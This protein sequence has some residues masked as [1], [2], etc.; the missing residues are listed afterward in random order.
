M[1]NGGSLF[2]VGCSPVALACSVN[3]M[4]VFALLRFG[5]VATPSWNGVDVSPLNS[6]GVEQSKVPPVLARVAVPLSRSIGVTPSPA[7]ALTETYCTS[8]PTVG[9]YAVFVMVSPTFAWFG[10]YSHTSLQPLL[11]TLDVRPPDGVRSDCISVKSLPPPWK[12]FRCF[13]GTFH[14]PVAAA[15]GVVTLNDTLTCELGGRFRF[16]S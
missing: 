9:V 16:R 6:H 13:A 11:P 2:G 5:N 15:H 4:P 12:S 3:S 14:V 7:T 1:L 8:P 10:G